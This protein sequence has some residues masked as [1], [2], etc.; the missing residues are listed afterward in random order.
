VSGWMVFAYE[1][2]S[3]YEKSGGCSFVQAWGIQGRFGARGGAFWPEAEDDRS[4][5]SRS[6]LGEDLTGCDIIAGNAA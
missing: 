4:E 3:G 1:T 5:S 6:A 2:A